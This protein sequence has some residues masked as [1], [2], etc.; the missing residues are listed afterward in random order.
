MSRHPLMSS[1]WSTTVSTTVS[2]TMAYSMASSSTLPITVV[3]ANT[4][5]RRDASTYLASPVPVR[6]VHR[7]KPSLHRD[8]WKYFV[9][10][11]N[12]DVGLS[13]SADRPS[14]WKSLGI[15]HFIV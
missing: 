11:S 5:V 2:S 1:I 8:T 6:E 14:Q 12:D 15:I 9:T 4:E 10:S 7:R 3:A 13:I